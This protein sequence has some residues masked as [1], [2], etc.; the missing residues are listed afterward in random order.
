MFVRS[1]AGAAVLTLVA[2]SQTAPPPP[3]PAPSPLAA[4]AAAAKAARGE[5]TDPGI[6]K[7]VAVKFQWPAGMTAT[8]ETERSKT[9][10]TPAGQKTTGTGI[11]YR[12]HV[13]AHP[14]GRL[15]TFDHFEPLRT[16]FKGDEAAVFQ[17]LMSSMMPSLIVN[18]RGDFVRVTNID[19]IRAFM[20]EFMAE[21]KAKAGGAAIPPNIQAMLDEMAS[22]K[23]LSSLARQDWDVI[24]GAWAGFTG[25]IGEFEEVDSEEPSPMVPGVTIPMRTRFGA[26]RQTPCE[27]GRAPDSCVVMQLRSVIAPGA[28]AS[29]VRR[30]LQGAKDMDGVTFDRFDVT[31]EINVI[32]EPQTGK[33][34]RIT[35]TRRADMTMRMGAQAATVTQ[36]EQRTSRISYQ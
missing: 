25:K 10:S 17:E 1:L 19:T 21:L 32:V 12:M 4:A 27:P 5:S 35:Q 20:R 23:V 29:V 16:V 6:G 11:K 26:A 7:P 22:E 33:P 13:A 31:T 30:L 28:M 14:Q 2:Q 34:F 18:T 8:I 15:I 3:P 9:Q 36:T 24:A